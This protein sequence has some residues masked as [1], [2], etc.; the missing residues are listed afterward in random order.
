MYIAE[1]VMVNSLVSFNFS[2]RVTAL[3]VISCLS[4]KGFFGV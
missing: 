1:R 2:S 4:E 3:L